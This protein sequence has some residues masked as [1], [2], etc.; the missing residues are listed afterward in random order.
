MASAVGIPVMALVLF[1]VLR[2][3][4]GSIGFWETLSGASLDLCIVS[5]G[6]IGGIFMN[7]PL[8]DAMDRAGPVVAILVVLV[9]MTLAGFVMLIQRRVQSYGERFKASLCLFL[10]ILAVGIPSGLIVFTGSQ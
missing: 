4:S 10:G 7:A 5:I 6:I 9:N 1:S 3:V 8:L 2:S